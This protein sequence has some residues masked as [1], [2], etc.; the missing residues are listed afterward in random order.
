MGNQKAFKTTLP[1]FTLVELL[2]VLALIGLLSTLAVILL[3]SARAKMRD[4][5][6]LKDL[7]LLQNTLDLYYRDRSAFPPAPGN[8]LVLGGSNSSCLNATGFNSS[9][10]ENPYL[11]QVPAD[12]VGQNAYVY[13]SASSSYAITATLEAQTDNFKGTV[14][15]TPSGLTNK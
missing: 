1:G 10:C 6:R 15:V 13:T 2:V 3:Q 14:V 12:P 5:V 11:A 8:G 4:S 7:S 9:G